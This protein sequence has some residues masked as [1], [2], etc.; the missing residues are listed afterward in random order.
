MQGINLEKAQQNFVD[1]KKTVNEVVLTKGL[2][3]VRARVGLVIDIS[4]SMS[5]LFSNGTVQAI[6]ERLLALGVKFD[7]N[8]AIDIFL[9]GVKGYEIGELH[10]SK[11]YDY[12]NKEITR[13]YALEGGTNYAGV[14]KRI[15]KK[16]SEERESGLK[17]FFKP[18]TGGK[19]RVVDPA[20]IMFLTDGDNQDKSE[21]EKIIR[22]SSKYPIFWQFVGIGSSRFPFLEKLDDLSGR[23]VDNCDFF[24][25]NDFKS[26]SDTELYNKLLTEFPNWIQQAKSKGILNV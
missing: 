23:V 21:A 17:K 20:Y 2:S 8:K 16:Y 6:V 15:V 13:M 22:E 11:F 24:H 12:V 4:L 19:N 10:E 9:F 3:D 18:F 1:L 5:N 7:D 25:L 26:I 14:M